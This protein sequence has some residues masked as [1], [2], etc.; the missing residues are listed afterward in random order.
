MLF[1][2]TPLCEQRGLAGGRGAIQPP[3]HYLISGLRAGPVGQQEEE[4]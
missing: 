2:T 4:M 1:K 3:E